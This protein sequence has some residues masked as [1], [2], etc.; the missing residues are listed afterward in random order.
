MVKNFELMEIHRVRKGKKDKW[1]VSDSIHDSEA[2]LSGYGDTDTVES[3]G[4]MVGTAINIVNYLLKRELN[5]YKLVKR[6]HKNSIT[7]LLD[8]K[9]DER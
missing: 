1:G 9:G 4:L 8:V 5:D 3:N 6:T 2:E 7:K